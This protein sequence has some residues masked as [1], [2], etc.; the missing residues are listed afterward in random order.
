MGGCDKGFDV[1]KCTAAWSTAYQ[2]AAG[3]TSEKRK[4]ANRGACAV[5]G[6][7]FGGLSTG[8]FFF[9][10]FGGIIGII[11]AIVF[12]CGICACCCFAPD[13]DAAMA[14]AAAAPMAAPALAAPAVAAPVQ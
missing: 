5:D 7:K 13:K 12:A 1:S 10:L 6:C 8:L 3:T 4:T 14:P 11:A 9:L 2:G